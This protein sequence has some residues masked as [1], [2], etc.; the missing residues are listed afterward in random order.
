[1]RTAAHDHEKP[2]RTMIPLR[3]RSVSAA[4]VVAVFALLVALQPLAGR[5]ARA[6]ALVRDWLLAADTPLRAAVRDGR[7]PTVAVDLATSPPLDDA[8]RAQAAAGYAAVATE[9]CAQRAQAG[10]PLAI[11]AQAPRLGLVVRVGERGVRADLVAADGRTLLGSCERMFADRWRWWPAACVLA[12]VAA[13]ARRPV[14]LLPA[15]AAAAAS[16]LWLATLR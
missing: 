5:P 3:L 7:L 16:A 14:V 1:M 10:E 9:W 4:A 15:L 12:L 2:H 13:L 11:D 6:F 8:A